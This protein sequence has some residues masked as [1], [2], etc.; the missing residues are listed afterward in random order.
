MGFE[1]IFG[2]LEI[3]IE[4]YY[5]MKTLLQDNISKTIF[6]LLLNYG[7]TLDYSF[8]RE[9]HK[10]SSRFGIQDFDECITSSFNT[11]NRI[12]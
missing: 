10:L 8:T 5:E 3:N 11:K 1:D 12:F 7:K 4:K 9:A 6:D 2:E